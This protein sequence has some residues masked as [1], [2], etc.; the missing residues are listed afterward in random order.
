[1]GKYLKL[2]RKVAKELGPTTHRPAETS[3][4]PEDHGGATKA[5]EATKA[6]VREVAPR[7]KS[8]RSDQRGA[9]QERPV[10]FDAR[11]GE[12]TTLAELKARRGSGLSNGLGGF[13]GRYRDEPLEV[14]SHPGSQ[15]LP[16]KAK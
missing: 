1:V 4:A 13:G 16:G 7:D 11:P 2:A 6:P 8:D 3:C 10:S 15:D 12:S 9:G 5:T 14:R